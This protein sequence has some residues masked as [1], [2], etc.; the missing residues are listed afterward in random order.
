M[1]VSHNTFDVCVAIQLQNGFNLTSCQFGFNSCHTV[2]DKVRWI[3]IWVHKTE[4]L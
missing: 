4:T 3:Q 1:Y 2:M